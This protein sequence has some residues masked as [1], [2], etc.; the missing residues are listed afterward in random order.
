[1]ATYTSNI[2]TAPEQPRNSQSVLQENANA[3]PELLVVDHI[4]FNIPNKGKHNKVTMPRVTGGV[5][6][7]VANELTLYSNAGANNTELFF[8]RDAS[9]TVVNM[10]ER[11]TDGN[12][13]SQLGWTFLPSGI[14]MVWG[15][16]NITGVNSF[17]YNTANPTFPG[18]NAGPM[19]QITEQTANPAFFVSINTAAGASATVSVKNSAGASATGTFRWIAIGR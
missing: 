14:K 19:L 7:P 16:A 8:K 3:I 18:F 17:N 2:P 12:T 6:A 9:A 10:T 5:P 11:S 15:T 4:G 1:M 13:G